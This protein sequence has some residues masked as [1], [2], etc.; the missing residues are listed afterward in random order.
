[1]AMLRSRPFDASSY[2][3]ALN[4]LT[5]SKTQTTNA[6][7]TQI[8]SLQTNIG[9]T[10]R[11][12]ST[13]IGAI[14]YNLNQFLG[15]LERQTSSFLGQQQAQGAASGFDVNSKSFL[16]S[17]SDTLAEQEAAILNR[18]YVSNFQRQQLNVVA[19]DRINA[20]QVNMAN[21]QKSQQSSQSAAMR[22]ELLVRRQLSEASNQYYEA[23]RKLAKAAKGIK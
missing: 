4:S 21:A 14:D 6:Y 10:Q 15:G 11:D 19:Q 7:N 13:N 5:E 2:V 18:E 23:Q 16:A 12:L 3:N 9:N 8:Q 22:Q 20:A 1:M 17:Y